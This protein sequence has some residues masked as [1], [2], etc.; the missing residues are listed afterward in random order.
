M[1]KDLLTKLRVGLEKEKERLEKE[2]LSFAAKDEKMPDNWQAGFPARETILTSS[3]SSQEEYADLR[4]EFEAELAQEQA[5]ELRL[6]EVNRAL[7]RMTKGTYGKCKTCGS[8][9][10]EARLAANPAAEYDIEHQPK[11]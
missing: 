3:H 9:I 4:E 8:F 5:L 2:L 10:S 1:E 7:D 11:E 6:R